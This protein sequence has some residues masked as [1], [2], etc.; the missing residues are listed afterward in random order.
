MADVSLDDLIKKDKEQNKL[1]R[2]TKVLHA[3][4]RS[5]DRRSSPMARSSKVARIKTDKTTT[6]KNRNR[7][8]KAIV[9]SRRSSSKN[10]SL[11]TTEIS[12]KKLVNSAQISSRTDLPNQKKKKRIIRKNSSALSKCLDWA[13]NSQTKTFTYQFFY[14]ETF[15]RWGSIGEMLD[16][17]G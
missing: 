1:N 16:R 5:L 15:C 13:L 2:Q 11:T 8:T 3:P 17:A 6:T 9:L 7:A 10:N 12:P 14:S 4:R